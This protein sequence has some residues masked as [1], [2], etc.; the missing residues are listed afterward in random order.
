[1]AP[2]V[3]ENDELTV[4]LIEAALRYAG[5]PLAI[6]SLQSQP[7]LFPFNLTRPLAYLVSNNEYLAVRSDGPNNQYVAL[8]D[9]I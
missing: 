1:L 4:W 5:K 8:R 7:V 3:V 9:M 2:T 6:S